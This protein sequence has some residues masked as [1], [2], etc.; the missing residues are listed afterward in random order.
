MVYAALRA[1]GRRARVAYTPDPA[2][3]KEILVQGWTEA[4]LKVILKKF[5]TRYADSLGRSF[6]VTIEKGPQRTRL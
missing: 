1:G 6:L 5:E 4:E 2:N 3:D